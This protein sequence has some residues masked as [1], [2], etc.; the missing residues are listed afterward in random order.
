MRFS[1]ADA[2]LIFAKAIEPAWSSWIWGFQRHN[3]PDYL[4]THRRNPLVL[5][6]VTG[7]N[8]DFLISMWLGYSVF[9]WVC[10]TFPQKLYIHVD[11]WNSAIDI[12]RDAERVETSTH[13]QTISHPPLKIS[14]NPIPADGAGFLVGCAYSCLVSWGNICPAHGEVCPR[15]GRRIG[16]EQFE[17]VLIFPGREGID[18]KPACN[19][20]IGCR[21]CMHLRENGV[22]PQ[23]HGNVELGRY[24]ENDD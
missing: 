11:P 23:I 4:A 8:S 22:Y 17:E 20:E 1:A 3:F 6:V 10:C 14:K 5:V 18:M 19:R 13:T 21:T 9:D 12:H 2:D 16:M 15:G 7:V 24:L